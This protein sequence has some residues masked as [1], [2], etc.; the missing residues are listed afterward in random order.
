MLDLN[1]SGQTLI[2]EYRNDSEG[3]LARI[4]ANKNLTWM[5]MSR[6]VPD[7]LIGIIDQIL[8]R[9]PDLYLRIFNYCGKLDVNCDILKRLPHLEKLELEVNFPGE[10]F[11]PDF[12]VLGELDNL[13][14][15]SLSAFNLKDY[16][17]IRDVTPKLEDLHIYADT[18]NG[19]IKFD[20]A[21]LLDFPELH[22]LCLTHKARKNIEAIAQLPKLKHLGL[23]S[24]KLPG[25]DFLIPL[26]LE[27]FSLSWC[28]MNDLSSLAHLNTLCG[29]ELFHILKLEDISCIGELTRLEWLKLA[30]LKHIKT[31][32]D[33]SRLKKLKKIIF[34]DMK[35]DENTLPT[36]IRKILSYTN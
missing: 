1:H 27:T 32:P 14:A 5:Q 36:E 13:R 31:L 29:L 28:G 10:S 2:E 23:R 18:Y 9:R 25:L 19:G 35:I 20:C 11:Q 7:E 30:Q 8:E 17:F 21:W 12:R 22:T 34:W 26:S 24:I 3:L 15:L 33:L 16:S 6:P 4:S